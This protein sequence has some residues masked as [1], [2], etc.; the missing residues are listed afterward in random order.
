M[1]IIP[2]QIPKTGNDAIRVQ[3]DDRTHLYNHLH[4]HPEIQV[5]LITESEGTLVAGDYMGRFQ[6]GDIFVIGSNQAHVFRNDPIY[7]KGKKR[8]STITVFFDETTLGIG[9]WN[10]PEL[11]AF[12][13]FFNASQGGYRI[14]GKKKQLIKETLTNINK[15]ESIEKLV[16][17]VQLIQ[18]L[19]GK[20]DLR[21]LSET[22]G[23]KAIKAFDGSRLNNILEFSF[24]ESHRSIR[25][26]EIASIANMSATAFCKYFKTRTGKSYSSFLNGIR[27]NNACKALLESDEIIATIGYQT[28]FNNLSNFNRIFKSVTGST[29]KSYR[30]FN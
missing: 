24:K 6:A 12:Q 13:S 28:G 26:E 17:F 16:L 15:K 4:Q 21:P 19:S 11:R 25:L 8:A 29:P 5:T 2:F 9:F 20:K 18:Q 14:L 3:L 27:V 1:K 30:A 10:S 23:Q 22:T 7:F